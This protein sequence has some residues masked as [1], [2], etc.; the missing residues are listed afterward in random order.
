MHILNNALYSAWLCIGL[1][2]IADFVLQIQGMLHKYKCIGWWDKQVKERLGILNNLSQSIIDDICNIADN[3]K[4]IAMS[5]KF[6]EYNNNV[7]DAKEQVSRNRNNFLAGMAC[8]C[9][10]WGIVTFFPLMFVMNAT[11]FSIVLSINIVIHGL[12]DHWKCNCEFINLYTDQIIH[13]L[14]IVVTVYTCHAFFL[15][16][17]TF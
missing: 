10:M 7:Y 3:E 2:L 17:L 15:I 1:H 11:T 4:R 6:M 13:L 9:I 5:K 16:P 14:Q 12:V 8:H